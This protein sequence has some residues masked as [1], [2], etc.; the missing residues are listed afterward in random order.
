MYL[1]RVRLFLIDI[2]VL[3][4]YMWSVRGYRLANL[5]RHIG[6]FSQDLLPSSSNLLN[7]TGK[8]PLIARHFKARESLRYFPVA[9]LTNLHPMTE[10]AL[11]L[12]TFKIYT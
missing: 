3:M 4:T 1:F 7:V 10:G 2:A 11:G 9:T 6:M 5:N 8:M 12:F